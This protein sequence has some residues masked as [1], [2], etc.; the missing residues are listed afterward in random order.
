MRVGNTHRELWMLGDICGQAN[1]SKDMRNCGDQVIVSNR[2]YNWMNMTT[3]SRG[4]SEFEEPFLS[5]SQAIR[6]INE[7]NAEQTG[8]WVYWL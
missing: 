7:W 5:D 1:L 3:G 8:I 2:S 4:K 6:L